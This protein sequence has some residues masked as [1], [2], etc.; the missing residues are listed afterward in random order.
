[1]NDSW[2]PAPFTVGKISIEH[3]S[4][5]HNKHFSKGTIDM[6]LTPNV[7]NDPWNPH[8]QKNQ[9]IDVHKLLCLI[10]CKKSFIGDGGFKMPP[11]WRN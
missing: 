3:L 4:T 2:F 1:M 11:V 6:K 10:L 5:F 7:G 9:I 8:M